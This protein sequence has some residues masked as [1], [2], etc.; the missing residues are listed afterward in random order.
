MKRYKNLYRTLALA[1]VVT[2]VSLVGGC[3]G[4]GSP[5]TNGF[6]NGGSNAT[7]IPVGPGIDGGSTMRLMANGDSYVY[8]V[9]GNTTMEF[10]DALFTKRTLNADVAGTMVRHITATTY[11]GVSCFEIS[12]N[13][14]YTPTGGNP[15]SVDTLRYVTQAA[16]GTITLIGQRDHSVSFDAA[17]AKPVWAG[18]FATG[19]GV[20]ASIRF[21]NDATD[22]QA[23][24]VIDSSFTMVGQESVPAT[25]GAFKAWKSNWSYR[26]LS[27]IYPIPRVVAG[28]IIPKGFVS[29]VDRTETGSEWW[30]PLY[31]APVRSTMTIAENDTVITSW[32]YTSGTFTRSDDVLHATTNLVMSL[33]AKTLN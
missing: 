16:D 20:S 29:Q 24:K 15:I 21:N 23:D 33:Q 17:T 25:V 12:D 31:T 3:G 27:N 1:G 32:T 2:T 30:L 7:N 18:A 13:L 10:L 5:A 11:N 26:E 4:S 8:K 28:I 19:S 14:L 9:T 22:L 6:P